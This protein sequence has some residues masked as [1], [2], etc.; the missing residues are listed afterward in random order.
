MKRKG[1]RMQCLQGCG[2]W[3]LIGKPVCRKCKRRV[4]LM[5]AKEELRER[6]RLAL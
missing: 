2:K 1:N 3:V 6:K 4:R 5:Q